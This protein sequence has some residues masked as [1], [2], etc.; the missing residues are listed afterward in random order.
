[1]RTLHLIINGYCTH[2]IHVANKAT[3]QSSFRHTIEHLKLEAKGKQAEIIV[4][5]SDNMPISYLPI[6][7]TRKRDFLN[8]R[9]TEAVLVI[10][11][12]VI[13]LLFF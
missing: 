10:S 7:G 5:D 9:L 3:S 12:V 2:S 6:E 1:M 4:C 8:H 13:F 11:S